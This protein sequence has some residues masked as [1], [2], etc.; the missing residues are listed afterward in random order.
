M[1][2]I[3]Q[4]ALLS[5]LISCNS[6]A[7]DELS[8]YKLESTDMIQHQKKG[9]SKIQIE[10]STLIVEGMNITDT[11]VMIQNFKDTLLTEE[12]EYN[13]VNGDSIK[14]AHVIKSYNPDGFLTE[15]IDS[16][17]GSLRRHEVHFY[18]NGDLV[19]SD[20]LTVI[21]R[22][23]NQIVQTNS[24][25]MRST[26]YCFY[27]KNG[28]H[29]KSI[30][31]SKN[32]LSVLTGTVQYD[33]TVTFNTFDEYGNIVLRTSLTNGDTTNISRTDYDKLGREILIIDG[34]IEFGIT[35][36]EF[37]YDQSGNEIYELI[38]SGGYK[39][40]TITSYDSQNRPIKRKNYSE[41]TTANMR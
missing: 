6:I 8:D 4:L 22:Y 9:D 37:K 40:L 29:F 12:I 24:D 38:N 14:W 3:L 10:Y 13:L 31:V 32:E 2:R 15:V 39:S 7:Q 1:I 16:L 26:V 27:N 19:R 33:S 20:F 35:T 17:D 34:S 11:S 23:N 41:K 25:T 28:E 36:M 30:S 5:L 18:E 21:P